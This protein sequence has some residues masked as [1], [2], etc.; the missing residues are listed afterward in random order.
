[1][2]EA[3]MGIRRRFGVRTA[4]GALELALLAF[5]AYAAARL[6][7]ALI[8]PVGPL[9]EWRGETILPPAPTYDFAALDPVFG[10]REAEGPLLVS[11]AGL[12]LYG[13]R[14]DRSSGRGSAI[15]GA[16]GEPQESFDI[17]EE[18]LP[19][20]LLASVEPDHVVLSRGGREEVLFLDQSEPAAIV[21]RPINAA[22]SRSAAARSTPASVTRPDLLE[23]FTFAPRQGG[24]PGVEIGPGDGGELFRRS[25]FRPGDALLTIDGADAGD[26]GLAQRQLRM[27]R[28]GQSVRFEVE[29]RGNRIPVTVRIP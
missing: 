1:M 24:E 5:L 19:G 17:G 23:E 13:L 14:M 28:S 20:V 8:T 4:Y 10:F 7:W 16:E 2:G 6:V 26:P 11:D 29:R 22:P 21:D 12:N 27:L 25:G 15:L 3:T 9:G 18:V